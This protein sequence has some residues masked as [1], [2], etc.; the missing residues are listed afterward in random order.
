MQVNLVS[1]TAPNKEFFDRKLKELDLPPKD[2]Y[3][4]EEIT[5][6]IA[7]V[8]SSRTNRLEDLDKLINYLIDNAH[9][10]PFEHVYMTVEIVTSRAI[11]RQLLRHRSFTFQEFSQ[12]YARVNEIEDVEIRLQAE[13]NRQSS[14]KEVAQI[15]SGMEG[16]QSTGE[17]FN[18]GVINPEWW[19]NEYG[20]DR[21]DVAD[22]LDSAVEALSYLQ[23]AYDQMLDAGIARECARMILPVGSQT[24]IFMTGN[25]RSWIHFLDLR[26]DPHSQKEAQLIGKE[27]KKIFSREFPLVA[28]ALDYD[29]KYLKQVADTGVIRANCNSDNGV[30][31]TTL[32]EFERAEYD[33]RY[34]ELLNGDIE[35]DSVIMKESGNDIIE[36]LSEDDIRDLEVI[37]EGE[38]Y[39]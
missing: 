35:I 14:T 29:D 33:I 1:K 17:H 18:W 38:L 19:G 20:V 37:V 11:G 16:T 6:Y 10:S 27:I 8:S 13:K 4:G 26:D 3:S 34:K 9:W 22:S 32:T 5:I 30:F 15:L 36:D 31:Y 12:R 28:H 25:L 24:T 23:D 2:D 39:G 21:D 7:R